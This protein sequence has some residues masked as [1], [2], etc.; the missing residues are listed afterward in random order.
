M[1]AS[2][3]PT[4]PPAP[5]RFERFLIRKWE[6][7]HPRPWL[8]FRLIAGCWNLF[9]AI[10]LFSYGF[11]WIGLIPLGGAALIFWASYQIWT[12]VHGG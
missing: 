3:H 10:T 11:Y 7:R 8:A 1:V 4:P 12:R 6:Y 2:A 5:S 9:L